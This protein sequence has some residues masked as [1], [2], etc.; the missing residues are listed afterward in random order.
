[1]RHGRRHITDHWAGKQNGYRTNCV[2][3][4]GCRTQ[5]RFSKWGISRY[6]RTLS[7]DKIED[8]M[9]DVDT[10]SR[11][12]EKMEERGAGKR[13]LT[14][15]KAI[16]EPPPT[17]RA[18]IRRDIQ[19]THSYKHINNVKVH[20]TLTSWVLN[21]QKQII[22]FVCI[23]I[24]QCMWVFWVLCC[25]CCYF[26]EWM[27]NGNQNHVNVFECIV[28]W[29]WGFLAVERTAAICNAAIVLIWRRPCILYY[30]IDKN[31]T[32]FY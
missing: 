15:C 10:S 18:S 13:M 32:L 5:R 27:F 28:L 12:E 22:V 7:Y 4:D 20:F 31:L 11:K 6:R 9:E 8:R 16:S 14:D 24:V 26:V 19:N 25:C 23:Y 2:D 21:G 3:I 29:G 1:M 17:H 30:F